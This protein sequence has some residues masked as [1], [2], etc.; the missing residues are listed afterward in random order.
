M[1]RERRDSSRNDPAFPTAFIIAALAE[2]MTSPQLRA[3]AADLRE[4]AAT[5]EYDLDRGLYE[6]TAAN[7]DQMAGELEQEAAA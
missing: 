7:L 3:A 6:Q 5:A 2:Q 1:H 4:L